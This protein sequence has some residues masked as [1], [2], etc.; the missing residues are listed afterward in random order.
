M[1]ESGFSYL[2]ALLFI[3]AA[4][5]QLDNKYKKF[6]SY[7]PGIVVIYFLVMAFSTFGVWKQTDDI[8][9][10]YKNL[11]LNLLPVMIFLMLLRCN[12]LKIIKLGPRMIM[13]FLSASFTIG[14]GFIV[15][16]TMF[17][18]YYEPYTWK[19]FAALAGSW[20]GGTGNMAAVQLA[21]GVTD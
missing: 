1:I 9:F 14:I 8:N 13:G 10:Y 3:V 17:K 21:L 2:A 12:I 18:S 6:F 11:K 4:V 20:M 19:T 5:V 16:F 7:V 15:T